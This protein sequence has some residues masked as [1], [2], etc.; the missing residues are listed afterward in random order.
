[1]GRTS[2]WMRYQGNRRRKH[3]RLA[4]SAASAYGRR[5]YW[6]SK[7]R[8]LGVP[9]PDIPEAVSGILESR[10]AQAWNEENPDARRKGWKSWYFRNRE[11]VREASRERYARRSEEDMAR[12]D[13]AI[14]AATCNGE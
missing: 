14:L 1:M 6:A 3:R 7:L 11:R 12:R 8:R 2:D 10:K 13:F 4:G 9:E 5:Y